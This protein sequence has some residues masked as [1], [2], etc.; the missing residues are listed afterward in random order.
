[1]TPRPSPHATPIPS[2]SR[3]AVIAVIGALVAMHSLLVML[4]VMPSNP[5]RDA[6]G[7]ENLHSYIDNPVV[8]FE[9]SWSIFA[10]V[11]RRGG[12]NVKVRAVI[13]GSDGTQ[14]RV[15][16][17]YDI[18]GDEDARITHLV[19]PSRIHSVTRRLGGDI[20]DSV[21]G[22][23]AEQQRA[24]DQAYPGNRDQLRKRL[25]TANVTGAKGMQA[26]DQYLVD[27]EMLVRFGTM[28]ATARWGKGVTAVEFMVGHR[29]VPDYS[30]RHE[31]D[32]L[33]MPYSYHRIGL[34]RAIA[35]DAGAQAAFDAYVHK[36]S[37][38][39]TATGD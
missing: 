23:N 15:T 25:V 34:R 22:F 33:D 38:S 13:G 10:P 17:W 24:I 20:N 30:R 2:A 26:I 6:V 18:T 11:P 4:W 8:P 36:A 28:Y 29:L 21:G 32:F 7:G 27:E 37:A 3:R 16:K 1:M 5:M 35:G 14:G 31:I 39:S 19:N 12:E 9:Q